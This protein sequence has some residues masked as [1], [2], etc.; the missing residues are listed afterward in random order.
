MT[1]AGTVRAADVSVLA[2]PGL[3]WVPRVK[4]VVGI[5]CGVLGAAWSQGLGLPSSS[6]LLSCLPHLIRAELVL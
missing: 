6:V 2:V 3:A 5:V 4:G 1:A